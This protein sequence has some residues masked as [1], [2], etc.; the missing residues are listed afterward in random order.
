[1]VVSLDEKL[2]NVLKNIELF[3]IWKTKKHNYDVS[4]FKVDSYW[5][6]TSKM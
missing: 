4:N 2:K 3:E 6:L 1:M 5:Q